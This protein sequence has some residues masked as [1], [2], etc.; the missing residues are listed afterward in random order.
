MKLRH[1]HI[2][3]LYRN[4]ETLILLISISV[5]IIKFFSVCH[6]FAPVFA[7]AHICLEKCKYVVLD[8]WL[9]IRRV[10][11]K[12]NSFLRVF[13]QILYKVSVIQEFVATD[14]LRWSNSKRYH[15]AIAFATKRL[16]SK[17][18]THTHTRAHTLLHILAHQYTNNS[19]SLLHQVCSNSVLCAAIVK[20]QHAIET[21]ISRVIATTTKATIMS[22]NNNKIIHRSKRILI[23]SKHNQFIWHLS[24]PCGLIVSERND[25][26]RG[27]VWRSVWSLQ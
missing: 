15:L 7:Y 10:G 4:W 3:L 11:R 16:S 18:S 24:L 1:K 21:A 2:V 26:G 22:G 14:V 25:R 6:D 5:I 13:K 8:W 27:S 20:L 12:L 17:W 19:W 9:L 23:K